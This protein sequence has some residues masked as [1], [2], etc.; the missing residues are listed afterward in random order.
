MSA[1]VVQDLRVELSDGSRLVDDASLR[2]EPGRVLGVVGESGSGKS[3]LSLALLGHAR[4]GARITAGSVRIGEVDMLALGDR[5]RRHARGTLIAYVPQDPAAALNPALSLRTQ[6][7]EAM[8]GTPDERRERIADVLRAV[9]LPADAAFLKRR[10]GQLSGG[11]KQRVGIAMA[12]VGDPDV[13]VLDEPTTG[14]DVTT[15]AKV[16]ALVA[17]LCRAREMAAVYISHDLAVIADVADEVAVMYAGQIIETGPAARL[18][19]A[20]QHPYS[21]ALLAS[22]P[23]SRV[24]LQLQAIPGRAP[25]PAPPRQGCRF[26]DRCGFATDACRRTA[27]QLIVLGDDSTGRSAVRC[28]RA[29]EIGAA[30]HARVE[31]PRTETAADAAALLEVRGLTAAYGRRPVLFDVDLQVRPGECVAVVGESGSGKS[32]LSQCI[33]GLQERTGGEVLLDGAALAPAA[34]RRAPAQRREVQYVFQN[35]Y[36]SLNPRATV[37]A[38][39][40]VP[41]T[42]FAG[43]GGRAR[44]SRVAELLDRVEL[45]A[46]VA[47]RYP[48]ELSGGQRQRV[49]IAR[50]LASDPRLL[51]CDEV[52]SALDVSVQAAIV[53]L[54][55]GLQAEGLSMLFVTHNFAVVRSLADAVTVLRAGTVVEQ[56]PT[57]RVLDQP[58][59][60]YTAT[61]LADVLDVPLAAAG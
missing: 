23:D 33:A 8:T 3:T 5:E 15:Q 29:G 60:E 44:R 7:E 37:G 11:Q 39:I 53:E 40:G 46:E 36:A 56:G 21:R 35:P 18:V 12:I 27:P 22:V 43:L 17:E 41:L 48:R 38:S 59:H 6:L 1:L 13:L 19:L 47:Q 28:L 54:L 57:D 49:A 58:E 20:P 50:A 4:P 2:V 34:R 25:A 42:Y 9:D 55:R 24:R 52:T 16:L 14:L 32:T 30:G 51:I 31:A 45:P 10:P 61:L 26:A